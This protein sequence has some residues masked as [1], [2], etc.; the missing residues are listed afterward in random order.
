MLPS[1]NAGLDVSKTARHVQ[2]VARLGIAAAK[3]RMLT[4]SVHST[5]TACRGGTGV[6]SGAKTWFTHPVP[7]T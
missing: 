4:Q 6:H 5:A 3:Q 7:D 1:R 2:T